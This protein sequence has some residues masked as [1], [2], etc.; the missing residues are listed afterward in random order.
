[1]SFSLS[2]AR[3]SP[4]TCAQPKQSRLSFALM[5]KVWSERRALARLDESRLEDLGLSSAKAAQETA[6]PIWDLPN[7]RL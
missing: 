6:R 2:P 1:M 7:H 3:V 4:H 5:I